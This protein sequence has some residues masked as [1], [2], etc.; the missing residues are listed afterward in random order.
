MKLSF[1]SVA[2]LVA[3][4]RQPALAKASNLWQLGSELFKNI[5]FPEHLCEG[6]MNKMVIALILALGL[7]GNGLAA[8]P[9]GQG[10]VKSQAAPKG[11]GGGAS[12]ATAGGA[13]AGGLTTGAIIGIAA[14]VAAAVAVTNASDNAAPLQTTTTTTTTTSTQ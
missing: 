11:P 12:G 4:K 7:V 1:P 5:L 8:A 13:A 14:A 2:N 9:K 10:A 3:N 6:H